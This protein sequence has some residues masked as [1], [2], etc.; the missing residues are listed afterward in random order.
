VDW[1]KCRRKRAD[2]PGRDEPEDLE[3]G[4]DRIVFWKA[5]EQVDDEDL[6]PVWIADANHPDVTL[7]EPDLWL[8]WDG[9]EEFVRKRG[10]PLEECDLGDPDRREGGAATRTRG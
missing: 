6:G 7:E 1:L 8:G 2:P 10:L 3:V 9:A 5:K 4:G